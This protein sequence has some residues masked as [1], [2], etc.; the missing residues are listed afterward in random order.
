[1]PCCDWSP[2]HQL[3]LLAAEGGVEGHQ[4]ELARLGAQPRV[5][6]QLL[7]QSHDLL[8]VLGQYSAF[9]PLLIPYI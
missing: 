6:G 2:E 7:V 3:L 5:R 9:F 4:Q 8:Q 1:M